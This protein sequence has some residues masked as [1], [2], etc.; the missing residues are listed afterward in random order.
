MSCKKWVLDRE[1]DMIAFAPALLTYLAPL[2][3]SSPDIPS[4]L[5]PAKARLLSIPEY[6]TNF[7]GVT[8]DEAPFL[9]ACMVAK[10]S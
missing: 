3:L 10:V 1:A 2:L 9:G 8:N 4:D 7:K 5:Q 6:F